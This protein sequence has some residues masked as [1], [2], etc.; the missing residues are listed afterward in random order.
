MLQAETIN[1]ISH[2]S[3]IIAYLRIY[4]LFND[5]ASSVV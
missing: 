3:F 4:V 5:S 2:K 1:K